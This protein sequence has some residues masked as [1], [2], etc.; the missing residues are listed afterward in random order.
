MANVYQISVQGH[1]DAGW[2][3]WFDG[4]EISHQA[5]GT[6]LLRGQID[7]QSALHGVLAKIRDLGLTLVAV[8]RIDQQS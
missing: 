4:L 8:Q 6:S 3:K 5:D 2:A 1:L 7:D